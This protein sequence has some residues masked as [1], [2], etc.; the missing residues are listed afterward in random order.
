MNN[1]AIN[2]RPSKTIR[3]IDKYAGVDVDEKP[4]DQPI[5]A[6][7]VFELYEHDD[8]S[9]T[10]VQVI[11]VGRRL[12]YRRRRAPG[13]PLDIVL[14]IHRGTA[15]HSVRRPQGATADTQ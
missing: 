4:W 6:Q 9:L 8:N 11:G 13:P 7:V 12:M 5:R 15:I 14:R 10:S 1:V 2:E 3:F